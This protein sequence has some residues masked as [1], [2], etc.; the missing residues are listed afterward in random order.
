[1][2]VSQDLCIEFYQCCIHT[3]LSTCKIYPDYLFENKNYLGIVVKQS[4]HPQINEYIR[5]VFDNAR[6]I[7]LTVSF[8]TILSLN[9]E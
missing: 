4:R 8:L 2:I 9:L 3:L 6:P 1:M 5:R 7:L